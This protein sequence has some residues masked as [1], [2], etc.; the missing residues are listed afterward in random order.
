MIS[1]TTK[2]IIILCLWVLSSHLYAQDRAEL[3][4]LQQTLQL[5]KPQKIVYESATNNRNEVETVFA[6]LFL[7]YKRFISSQD[8]PGKCTFH[9]SCSVYGIEAVKKFGSGKGLLMTFDR[10]IRC[11]G[12]NINKYEIDTERNLFKDP[13][14]ENN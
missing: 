1:K 9:P 14:D 2:T 3:A 12:L 8:Y 13:V 10:L 11:N 5:N 7:F 4:L 6:G